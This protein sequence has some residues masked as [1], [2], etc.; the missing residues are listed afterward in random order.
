MGFLSDHR[1]SRFNITV[2]DLEYSF[3]YTKL[4]VLNAIHP[5]I[6]VMLLDHQHRH[7]ET[8]K[9]N[10]VK[11]FFDAD[12]P[13]TDFRMFEYV[14]SLGVTDVFIE[15]DLCYNLKKVRKA[16]DKYG[17]QVRLII[18]QIPSSLPTKTTDVRAP[19]FIPETVDELDK[20][21][22]IIEFEE[23]SWVRMETLYKIWFKKKKWRGNL[24]AIIPQL[25]IDIWNDSMIPDFT[26]YKMNCGYRCAYGSAC[27]KCNQFVEMAKDL[28]DKGIE[29]VLK[30]DKGE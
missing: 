14:C 12:F 16:A 19:W 7:Y 18:N 6:Y 27:K 22:D 10:N 9:K 25:E 24:K 1:D 26:V 29:Y 13:I 21:I 20:Y 8:L 3:D 17:V 30:E 15:D 28:H 4:K 23:N 5:Q 2:D 11:F